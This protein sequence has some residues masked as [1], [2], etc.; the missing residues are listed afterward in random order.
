LSNPN[1]NAALEVPTSLYRDDAGA[2]LLLP[3]MDYV[4]VA[5]EIAYEVYKVNANLRSRSGSSNRQEL[6]LLGGASLYSEETLKAGGKAVEGLVLA[7]PWFDQAPGAQDF[8]KAATKQWGGQV[9]WRTATSYD[10][11]QAFITALSSTS[12]PSRLIVLQI[13]RGVNIPASQTSGTA[14]QFTDDGEWKVKPVLVRIR[15]GQFEIE[16]E[17]K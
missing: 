3:D 1:L 8:A 10:A 4:S 5:R 2:I 12:N 6:K 11:T 14:L 17:N 7:V 9:S 15:G 16:K 13:L